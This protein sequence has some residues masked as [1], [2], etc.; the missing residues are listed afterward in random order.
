MIWVALELNSS[1]RGMASWENSGHFT[2]HF[3]MHVCNHRRRIRGGTWHG[4]TGDIVPNHYSRS[5]VSE[6]Y[7]ALIHTLKT[8]PNNMTKSVT[9]A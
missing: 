4:K 1:S 7:K 5:Q 9:S 2:S 6:P 8:H 3:A